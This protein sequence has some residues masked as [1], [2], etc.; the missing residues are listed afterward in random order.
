M[1]CFVFFKVVKER[2]HT[3]SLAN[4]MAGGLKL[5]SIFCYVEL[6]FLLGKVG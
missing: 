2:I 4:D 5:K 6:D 3:D 1:G